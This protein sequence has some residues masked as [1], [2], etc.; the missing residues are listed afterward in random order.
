MT[1]PQ[2]SGSTLRFIRQFREE[3]VSFKP[4][5]SAPPLPSTRAELNLVSFVLL[6]R[7]ACWTDS[8]NVLFFRIAVIDSQKILESSSIIEIVTKII[9]WEIVTREES[10]ETSLLFIELEKKSLQTAK[11]REIISF[12]KKCKTDPESL[13]TVLKPSQPRPGSPGSVLLL[14]ASFLSLCFINLG[15]LFRR[16]YLL[17]NGIR[18]KLKY[19]H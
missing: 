3:Y 18:R 17:Q 10:Q 19:R 12:A 1:H 13:S 16:I 15:C 7:R 11:F 9:C 4:S 2:W 8:T 5:P 6:E 14:K